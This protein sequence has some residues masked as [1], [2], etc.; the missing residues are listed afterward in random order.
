MGLFFFA[1]PGIWGAPLEDPPKP[2][3]MLG[4]FIEGTLGGSFPGILGPAEDLAV[5]GG[6]ATFF[7]SFLATGAAFGVI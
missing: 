1:M 4:A 3:G 7:S 5:A 6:D 2:D